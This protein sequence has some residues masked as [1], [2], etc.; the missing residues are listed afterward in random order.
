MISV[1]KGEV[2]W[3]IILDED[4]EPYATPYVNEGTHIDKGRL[5][6]KNSFNTREE[7][8][9]MVRK[10]HAVLDGADV[11]KLPSKEEI[12]FECE[13]LLKSSAYDGDRWTEEAYQSGFEDG[14]NW[15]KSQLTKED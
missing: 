9:V 4:D 5:T 15:L 7:A 8:E 2:Y 1:E 3:S 14:F 6:S 10:L 11:I 12:E 13:K